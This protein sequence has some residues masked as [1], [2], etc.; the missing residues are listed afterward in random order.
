[1]KTL[2]AE[3]FPYVSVLVFLVAGTYRVLKWSTLP[4]RLNWKLYPTPGG[5]LEEGKYILEEWISFGMLFRNQR[6]L[7][8]GSYAFHLSLVVLLVWFLAFSVWGVNVWWLNRAGT[9]LMFASTTYMLILRVTSRALRSISTAAEYFHLVLFWGLSLCG[10]S[11][12]G[13][14]IASQ[15]RA[16]LLSIV[17]FSPKDPP[18]QF[19]FLAMLLIAEF[20]IAYMPMSKM[21]HIA[22]KFFAFHKLR[23]FNPYE[24]KE[25][26]LSL[27]QGDGR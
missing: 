7:W 23:W 8:A 12:W 17:E 14:G 20:I 10:I 27:A 13:Q 2:V 11:L 1:M 5:I 26:T 15:A 22:S 19:P 18:A 21:F 3:I 25:R 6:A 4:K 9:G 24:G 16:Y